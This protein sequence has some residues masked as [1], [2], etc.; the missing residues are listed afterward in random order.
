MHMHLTRDELVH[1]LEQTFQ[2]GTES[3]ADV[4]PELVVYAD[5]GWRA[6]DI[7]A[8]ITAWEEE[9]TRALEAYTWG[10]VYRIPDFE[11]ERY[12]AAT[13][14][15]RRELSPDEVAD[16]WKAARNHL[17]SMVESLSP[18]QL[19][20]E[21]GYPS[22]RRG[23]C[24]ALIHEVMEHSQKHIQDAVDAANAA[25]GVQSYPDLK[26]LVRQLERTQY[27]GMAIL[28]ELDPETVVYADS[29]WRV[30]DIIA[31]LIA[32]DEPTALCFEAHARGGEYSIPDYR[33]VEAFNWAEYE[34]RRLLPYTDIYAGWDVV[35]T[36]I[37]E[38]VA[39]LSREQL[40]GNMRYPSGN[41]GLCATLIRE[42]WEH[43][44]L[45]F[46]DILAALEK[47]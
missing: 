28:A 13:Y 14:K 37:K 25:I 10:K 40:T 26:A 12:N 35:R 15:A 1:Q 24:A 46:D 47:S 4:K 29:G 20:G 21:M 9:V 39:G 45:H 5:S 38:A 11:L 6:Q 32:W 8:H 22:G 17:I 31:H 43:Q 34:K 3:L 44:Q 27:E 18:K 36:R 42:V 41:Q 33:G 30:K 23:E 2:V 7:I 16:G 19:A